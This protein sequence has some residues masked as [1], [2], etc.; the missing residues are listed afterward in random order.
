MKRKMKDKMNHRD[1]TRT[2]A[3][4]AAAFGLS[5][6]T[7]AHPQDPPRDDAAIQN[8]PEDD[9]E[10]TLDDLLGLDEAEGD[11]ADGDADAGDNDKPD[12]PADD[13]ADADPAAPELTRE[14]DKRLSGEEASEQFVQ[15]IQEMEDVAIRLGEGSD[16]GIDTQRMQDEIIVKLEQIIASAEKSPSQQQ[17]SKPGQ[18]GEGKPRQA[19]KGGEQ[20]GEQQGEQGEGEGEQEGQQADGQQPGQEGQEGQN[21]QDGQQA[22][23]EEGEGG[24]EGEQPGEQ[25]ANANQS[26]D[27]AQ[28]GEVRNA[29]LSMKDLREGEWGNLPPRLRDELSESLSEEFNP[30]YRAA[31]EAFYRRIAELSG[32]QNEEGDE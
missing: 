10:P 1:F 7:P 8:T 15:A 27:N 16:P 11:E 23:G 31:T 19:D 3:C 29:E 14:L 28:Q 18:P 25:Q 24:E 21:G 30:V 13:K 4:L 12:Q 20:Q 26:G 32:Q 22:K 6:P 5:L 2:L 9:S 17:Q